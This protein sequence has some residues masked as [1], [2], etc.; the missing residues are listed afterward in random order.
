MGTNPDNDYDGGWEDIVD[1]G[2]GFE[3][4]LLGPQ[5]RYDMA[6]GHVPDKRF[7]T[8][9]ALRAR[10]DDFDIENVSVDQALSTGGKRPRQIP[11][12]PPVTAKQSKNRAKTKGRSEALSI[13]AAHTGRTVYELEIAVLGNKTNVERADQLDTTVTEIC[14]LRPMYGETLSGVSTLKKQGVRSVTSAPKTAK[15]A[16]TPNRPGAPTPKATVSAD[17]PGSAKKQR[18]AAALLSAAAAGRV[19]PAVAAEL[20]HGPGSHRAKAARFEITV[21]EVQLVASA[22]Q[23]ALKSNG[24]ALLAKAPAPRPVPQLRTRKAPKP[25]RAAGRSKHVSLAEGPTARNYCPACERR[26]GHDTTCGCS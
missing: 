17:R 22:Y 21:A 15:S 25:V 7:A 10:R 24:G 9:T 11:P 14:R 18:Q 19:T 13:V 26:I 4:I 2:D 3:D 6:H 16:P 20:L 5:Q 23:A 12:P 8:R 1:S